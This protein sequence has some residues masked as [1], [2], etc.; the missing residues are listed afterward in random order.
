MIGTH[1]APHPITLGA[2]GEGGSSWAQPPVSAWPRCSGNVIYIFNFLKKLL[3]K[4]RQNEIDVHQTSFP[5]KNQEAFFMPDFFQAAEINTVSSALGMKRGLC[6]E[7]SG[8]A[9]REDVTE[10]NC[11]E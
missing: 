2:P 10:A 3:K 4:T 11:E 7:V 9:S 6:L 1:I 8:L 5:S